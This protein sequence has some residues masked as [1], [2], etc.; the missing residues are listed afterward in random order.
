M[1]T[2]NW[3]DSPKLTKRTPC[4]SAT[5]FRLSTNRIPW[6]LMASNRSIRA[7]R[8]TQSAATPGQWRSL[9]RK[10]D[11]RR[12]LPRLDMLGRNGPHLKRLHGPEVRL[13]VELHMLLSPLEASRTER[14]LR[15]AIKG[16]D[17]PNTQ[18]WSAKS[19]SRTHHAALAMAR[20]LPLL[21]CNSSFEVLG[22][23]GFNRINAVV[24]C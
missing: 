11:S 21:N 10:T 9:R 17:A 1:V 18:R 16:N 19:A 7:S 3:R 8:R 4:A 24:A 6:S 2:M 23:R 13:K 22:G 12:W 15:T 5:T 20:L 14:P